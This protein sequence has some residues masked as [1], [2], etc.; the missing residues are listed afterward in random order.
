MTVQLTCPTC[1][2]IVKPEKVQFMPFCSDRCKQID[3]GR[4]LSERYSIPVEREVDPDGD[5]WPD[6]S[7]N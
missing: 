5:E 2:A 3:L 6:A 7:N 4:W 1:G